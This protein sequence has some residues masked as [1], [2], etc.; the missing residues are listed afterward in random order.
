MVEGYK[1]RWFKEEDV[2]PYISGLNQY[3]YLMYD[4]E[5]FMW[6]FHDSPWCFESPTIAVVESGKGSPVAFNGFLPLELSIGGETFLAVQGCDGFVHPEH[7]RSGLFA[8][9]IRFMAAEL[10]GKGPEFLVGFNFAGAAGAAQ[11]AGSSVSSDVQRWNA[12]HPEVSS[13]ATLREIGVG[14][15]HDL[16]EEWASKSDLIHVHRT[17]RYLEWRYTRS[18]YRSHR[19]YRW[20]HAGRDGYL[21]ASFGDEQTGVPDAALEDYSP[22]LADAETLRGV[23][24]ALLREAPAERLWLTTQTGSPFEAAAS[25]LGWQPE[26]RFTVIMKPISGVEAEGNKLTRK[27]RMLTDLSGWLVAGSDIY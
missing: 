4:K 10:A 8:E 19:M 16:Y 27:G 26:P 17:R 11:K 18:P 9:T 24:S 15:L 23:A 12:P 13:G 3:L 14:E 2:E 22:S 20:E 5:R 21:V 7:R 1:V 6:K 25:R